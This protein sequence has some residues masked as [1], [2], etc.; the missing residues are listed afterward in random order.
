MRGAAA[1]ALGK[2]RDATTL[3]RILRATEDRGIATAVHAT[4]ALARFADPSVRERLMRLA[5]RGHE[6]VRRNAALGLGRQGGEDARQILL[7]MAREDPD[8]DARLAAF[9]ALAEMGGSDGELAKVAADESNPFDFKREAVE[10]LKMDVTKERAKPGNRRLLFHHIAHSRFNLILPDRLVR[11][12]FTDL[13][14]V[15]TEELIP[16]P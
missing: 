11:V 16:A 1:W 10:I 5:K 7:A 12:G 3:P 15:L 6:Q 8:R 4:V 13:C 9:Q 2:L 14:G